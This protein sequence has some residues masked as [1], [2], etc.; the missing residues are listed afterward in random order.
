MEKDKKK[1][2]TISPNFKK[3]INTNSISTQGKK[4]YSVEKKKS[5]R[6]NKPRQ[7]VGK[8]FNQETS[9]KRNF[10]RKYIELQATK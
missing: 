8:N 1:T 4:S 6:S 7:D 3:K 2:L 5:F 9:K 10:A